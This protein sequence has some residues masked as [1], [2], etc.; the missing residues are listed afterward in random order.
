MEATAA[1]GAN[2]AGT[3][4]HLYD[5]DA[6]PDHPT[7]VNVVNPRASI[8]GHSEYIQFHFSINQPARLSAH[9]VVREDPCVANS[10]WRPATEF[11]EP[12]WGWVVTNYVYNGL[13]IFLPNGTFY[14]E[15]RTAASDV[16][17][18]HRGLT[19]RL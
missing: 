13:H 4:D 14:R 12:I 1:A 9:F 8:L 2:R 3:Q 19:E 18:R 11:D 10:P 5:V 16:D 6:V 17:G 15:V 7:C